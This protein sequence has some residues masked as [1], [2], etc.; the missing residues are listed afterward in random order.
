MKQPL[1]FD[2]ESGFYSSKASPAQ[3]LTRFLIKGCSFC[4]AVNFLAAFFSQ[5]DNRLDFVRFF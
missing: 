5:S 4:G 2:K 3:R 1:E